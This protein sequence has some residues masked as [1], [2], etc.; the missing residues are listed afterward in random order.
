M[1]L[2]IVFALLTYF[3]YSVSDSIVKGLGQGLSI[4]EIQFFVSIF[5]LI[6]TVLSKPHH[7]HWREVLHLRHP[8]LLNL[9]CISGYISGICGTYAFLT[10]P[11]AEAYSLIFLTPIFVVVLSIPL[12][13]EQVGPLRWVILAASFA[14]A[15]IVVR[16][17]FREFQLG[18]LSAVCCAFFGAITT[19]LLK[20]ISATERRISIMIVPAI[21][22]L[23]INSV[24]MAMAFTPPTLLQ[25]ASLLMVGL[26]SGTATLLFVMAS[27]IAPISRISL[28][29]YSQI[30]WG[31]LLG[32]LIYGE[33]PDSVALVGMAVVVIAGLINA[34]SGSRGGQLLAR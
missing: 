6:P 7:E 20:R 9:R 14:G 10:I 4:G 25:F 28:A 24:L 31:G 22:S 2:G 16:P 21:Y 32:A 30:V 12:F 11:L 34:V 3:A 1:S 33:F 13:G 29:H 8:L 17:G 23:A 27:K 19:I 5:G 26:C 18:H 15:L